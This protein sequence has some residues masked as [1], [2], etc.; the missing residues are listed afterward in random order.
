M[1][2]PIEAQTSGP[3]PELKASN[4]KDLVGVRKAPMSTVSG[5][6][7]AELGV[8]MLEGGMQVRPAQLPGPR[9]ARVGLLRRYDAP[10]DGLV[11]RRGH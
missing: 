7:L 10:P 11:G 9:C 3:I 5:A 4:P 1:E 2:N 8:A 6:V